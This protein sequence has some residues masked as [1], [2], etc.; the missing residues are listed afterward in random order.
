MATGPAISIHSQDSESTSP[1]SPVFSSRGHLRHV[2]SNSSLA[3]ATATS[4]FDSLESPTSAKKDGPLPLLVEEPHE[5]EDEFE[6]LEDDDDVS[7]CLCDTHSCAHQRGSSKPSAFPPFNPSYDYDLSDSLV[8]DSDYPMTTQSSIRRI[9][10][11]ETPSPLT[12]RLVERFPSMS[13]HWKGRKAALTISTSGSKS[14]PTSRAA[15]RSSSLT[16][17]LLP[18]AE[19]R[20]VQPPLTPTK[21]ETD[22]DFEYLS[23]SSSISIDIEKAKKDPIDREALASTPLLPPVLELKIKDEPVQS[24]LQSP[25]VADPT[26]SFSFTS[27]PASTPQ[28]PGMPTPPLSSKPS[29]SSFRHVRSGQPVTSSDVPSLD[30]TDVVDEWSSKLGHANFII[31]P[32]PYTPDICDAEA[33]RR[34]LEAWEQARRN[35]MK[36]QLRTGEHYGTTSKTYKLT[37]Q[38]W[39]QIDA[40]WKTNHSLVVATAA[41]S[42]YTPEANTP[43]EPAPLVK[44]PTLNDPKSE[45]KFPK[46]GDEDIVGPMVQIASQIQPKPA[47]KSNFLKFFSDFKFSGPLLGNKTS[48]SAGLR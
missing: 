6:I 23:S 47:K 27:S 33:C 43:T 46:L 29:I 1:V 35:F 45:G 28:M 44:M 18:I 36:H 20:A 10:R 7:P 13:K 37:N 12:T 4:P 38:K 11:E 5:R 16:G 3:S 42:G 25:T 9:S 30:M 39:A 41:R 26:R 40:C 24:P 48:T 17:S 15:S 8:S 21:S 22:G 32:Q 34:L 2:S 19:P 14:V 31:E